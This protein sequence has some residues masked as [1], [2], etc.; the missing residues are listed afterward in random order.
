MIK[1]FEKLSYRCELRSRETSILNVKR[2][3]FRGI[4]ITA[5]GKYSNV[6]IQFVI[7]AILSRLLSPG[8]Y[9]IVAIVNVFLVFFSMLVD[10]GIGPAIIQNKTLNRTQL[11]EIF[12]FSIILSFLIS[13]LFVFFALPL[14]LFYGDKKLVSVFLLMSIVLLFSGFNIVP[15][16]ILSKRKSFT[17]LNLVQV[18]ATVISGAV[19]VF[20]AFKNFSYYSLITSSIVR[21]IIIYI[22]VKKNVFVH[23]NYKIHRSSLLKIY[24][25]S[26]DQFLFN[27]IN[28][29]SRNLDNILIGKFMSVKTLGYY[30]KAYTLSL[31]PNQLLSNVISPVLQ[32]IMSEYEKD[33]STILSTYLM[34]TK[35]LSLIG[36]PLSVYIFFSSKEIIFI[37]F[38]NQWGNSVSI[39]QILSVSIGVQMILSSTGVIFQSANRPDLLLISG[40]LSAVLNI[41]SIVIGVIMHSVNILAT[42]LVI[43]FIVNFFQAHYLLIKNVFKIKQSEY[44]RVLMNPSIIAVLVAIGLWSLSFLKLPVMISLTIKSISSCFIFTFG[45]IITG[46]LNEVQKLFFGRN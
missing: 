12:T 10:M 40:L 13:L 28:Y 41:V 31:Y 6:I 44:Y 11:N 29:F 9:G 30:D 18:L 7:T 16:A 36:F 8:E 21:S 33:K 27:F 25:F 4:F 37:L 26:K 34:I 46:Q 15:Q 14:S 42:I 2:E 5:I 3:L 20:L 38:G 24:H 17:Y 1:K 35:V 22:F 45:L 19:G 39:L 43:S 32:P 23:I